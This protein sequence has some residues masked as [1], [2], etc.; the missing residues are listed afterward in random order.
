MSCDCYRYIR[1]KIDYKGIMAL[2]SI[3]DRKMRYN[4]RGCLKLGR[5]VSYINVHKISDCSV[6]A[7]YNSAKY[8]DNIP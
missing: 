7:P 6:V 1:Y 3:N 4:M 8:P 2:I 5:F